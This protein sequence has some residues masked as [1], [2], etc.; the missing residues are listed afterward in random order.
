MSF[1]LMGDVIE[2]EG[3]DVKKVGG[4]ILVKG[5]LSCSRA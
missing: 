3:I 2:V 5:V 4:D 1:D